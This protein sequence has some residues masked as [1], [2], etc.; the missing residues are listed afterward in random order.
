VTKIEFFTP[1]QEKDKSKF[2]DPETGADLE[3]VDQ[4]SLVEWFANHYK[5]FGAGGRVIAQS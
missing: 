5:E 1:D 2:V 3:V 4:I